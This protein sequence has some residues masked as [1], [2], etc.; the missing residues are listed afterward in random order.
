MV[1]VEQDWFVWF[2]VGARIEILRC[3]R[4]IAG[5]RWREAS[6]RQGEQDQ[7][8]TQGAASER[9]RQRPKHGWAAPWAAKGGPR[10]CN[11]VLTHRPVVRLPALPFL[12]EVH[13][14]FLAVLVL[15]GRGSHAEEMT[16]STIGDSCQVVADRHATR[17][18]EP[19]RT[20]KR[21]HISAA[22]SQDKVVWLNLGQAECVRTEGRKLLAFGGILFLSLVSLVPFSRIFCEYKVQ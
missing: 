13:G 16:A 17:G 4:Q 11:I 2:R 18:E 7:W 21:R 14:T 1:A 5:P 12:L 3:K 6:P 19:A 20:G 15:V 10:R 8:A 22:Q 9:A